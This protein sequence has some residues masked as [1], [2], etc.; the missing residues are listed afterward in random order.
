MK[1]FKMGECILSNTAKRKNINNTPSIE[2]AAHIVESVETLLDPLREA[3]ER[4]CK[5]HGWN[6]V[7]IR[8]SSGYR[9]PDLN[10]KVGGSSTSAHCYGY[11]FDLIPINGKMLEFKRFC[12]TFLA[13]RAFDQ[14]IS[15]KEDANGVPR[16]M[17]VGYKYPDGVQQRRQYLY[18]IHGKPG[19]FSDDI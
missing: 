15:E 5:Q 7:R 1:Y 12:R 6:E 9:C 16:W 14:L 4:H 18:S 2:I 17:H 11:A 10:D 3:W 19:L 13:N 8:I